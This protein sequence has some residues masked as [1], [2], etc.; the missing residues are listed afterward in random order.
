MATP[1]GVGP[2]GLGVQ[3]DKRGE[4][5]AP[6]HGGSSWGFQCLLIVHKLKKCRFAAMTNGD[7]VGV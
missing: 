6:S 3:I 4:G 5:C 1:V 7:A 2:F